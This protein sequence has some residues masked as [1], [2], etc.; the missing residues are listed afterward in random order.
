[1]GAVGSQMALPLREGRAQMT[2]H[3]TGEG[4]ASPTTRTNIESAISE[5]AIDTSSASLGAR[6]REAREARGL[7]VADVAAELRLPARLIE[8][9]E[10]NDYAGISDGVF[11]RGYLTSY[12]RLAGVPLAEA[13][14]VADA[15][16]KV[17]PLVA[18]GTISRSR[19]LFERYSASATY[20]TLTAI[21]VVPAVWLATHGGLQQNL[22][23]VTPL[24]P[25]PAHVVVDAAPLMDGVNGAAPGNAAQTSTDGVVD[26]L[27]SPVPE[28]QTPVIASMAP[29]PMIEATHAPEPAKPTAD[30]P[31]AANGEGAHVLRLKVAQQSWVEVTAADGRKLEYSMLP[32]DSEHEYRSDGALSVRVGN[33]Q[34]AEVHADGAVVDLAPFQR[35]NVAHLKLFG[36]ASPTAERPQ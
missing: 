33:A 32:A 34:G 14:R 19:Y 10:Q 18:T 22:A 31:N 26:A 4:M 15:N 8:R 35:G 7:G 20:L 24:D 13:V 9:L 21:I 25:P 6:L 16:A 36:D 2:N 1:M 11:L 28:Q 27:P 23:R 5:A 17:A 12:A 30:T 29:F 3:D